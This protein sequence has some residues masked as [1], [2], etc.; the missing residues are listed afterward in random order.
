MF[1][2][3]NRRGLN[4]PILR[5]LWLM[6]SAAADVI[7]VTS[8]IHM[9]R[10]SNLIHVVKKGR[11]VDNPLVCLF[12][13]GSDSHNDNALMWVGFHCYPPRDRLL[14]NPTVVA[15]SGAMR[16]GLQLSGVAGWW[17][18]Y[19]NIYWGTPYLQRI[20]GKL[21]CVMGACDRLEFLPFSKA[22]ACHQGCAMGLSRPWPTAG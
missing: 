14:H 5:P 21:Q 11:E 13:A 10:F 4:R 19:L 8:V 12:Y 6:T 17:L 16:H 22:N 15:V 1:S 18:A 3:Q 2:Y 20:M 7:S 9:A